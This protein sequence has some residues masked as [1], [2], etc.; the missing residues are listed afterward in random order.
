MPK[1]LNP[2]SVLQTVV[3][4]ATFE[5]IELKLETI[6]VLDILDKEL[7]E[8]EFSDELDD[9]TVELRKLAYQLELENKEA[10]DAASYAD[11]D[12]DDDDD[13][14]EF[15]IDADDED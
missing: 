4:Q 8:F 1:I 11:D 3:A 14:V 15:E 13:D 12:D 5:D 7:I 6:R 9:A 2:I 10:P